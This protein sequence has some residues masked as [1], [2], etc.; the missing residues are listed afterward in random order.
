MGAAILAMIIFIGIP[1]L[2]PQDINSKSSADTFRSSSASSSPVPVKTTYQYGTTLPATP[3]PASSG[4]T[5]YRSGIAYEQVYARDYTFSTV[6]QDIFS[7]NLQQAPLLIEC[8]MNPKII[9]REQ[10]V[11]IGKSTERYLT[12][13]YPDPSAWLDLKVINADTGGVVTTIS[14]SKNY[15]GE[16]KQTYTLR[17]NGNYRFEM[18]GTLVSPGVRLLVKK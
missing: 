8:D 14:F 18:A 11:D 2:Q 12:S 9:S 15:R 6:Q 17:A 7:Y 4:T 3:V 10:L 1:L 5:V 16:L 13:A